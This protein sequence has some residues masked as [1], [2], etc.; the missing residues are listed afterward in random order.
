MSNEVSLKRK[1]NPFLMIQADSQ[2]WTG[3]N[4]VF[5]DQAIDRGLELENKELKKIKNKNGLNDITNVVIEIGIIVIIISA[6]ILGFSFFVGWVNKTSID[7]KKI[8]EAFI[9][10]ATSSYTYLISKENKIDE[11][12]IKVDFNEEGILMLK[13]GKKRWNSSVSYYNYDEVHNN[14]ANEAVTVFINKGE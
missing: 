12:K 3:Y 11:S 13:L 9:N 14:K 8:D 5:L 6:I 7:D 4:T 2:N 10:G 1:I